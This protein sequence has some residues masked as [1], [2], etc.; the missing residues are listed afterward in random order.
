MASLIDVNSEWEFLD[1]VGGKAFNLYLMDQSGARVPRWFAISCHQ[2]NYYYAEL[3][4][5]ILEEIKKVSLSDLNSLRA[6]AQKIEDMFLEIELDES[7]FNEIEKRLNPE[8]SYSVRSSAKGEDGDQNSFAGQLATFLNCKGIEEVRMAIKK[9]WAS[10]FSERNIQYRILNEIHSAPEVGVIIQ[11]LIEVKSSGVM[12]TAHPLLTDDYLDQ[13]VI[14]AGYGLG[15]GIVS[16]TV[17]VDTYVYSKRKRAVIEHQHGEKTKMVV[18]NKT[19]TGTYISDVDPAK[20]TASVL[21]RSQIF[22]LVKLGLQLEELFKTQQDIEWCIDEQGTLYLTQTRPITTLLKGTDKL[23]FLFDNSNIVESFPGVNTPWTL[24]QVKDIYRI[25]FKRTCLRLGFGRNKINENSF[26]FASLL[27]LYRGRVYLNLTH[28]SA[29]MRLVPFTDR[30]VKAWEESLG[31]KTVAGDSRPEY[32]RDLFRAIIVFS[33]IIFYLIFLGPI[34]RRLDR[35]QRETFDQFWRDEPQFKALTPAEAINELESFKAK[36]FEN[37]EFTLINDIFAFSFTSFTKELIKKYSDLDPDQTFNSLLLGQ[38]SMDSVKPLNS[39]RQLVKLRFDS[40]ELDGVLRQ[41]IKQEN[42]PLKMI[43]KAQGGQTF[44][45]YFFD[46]IDSYGDRGVNELKLETMTF[47][48][49]P[50]D[51]LRLIL[52]YDRP[53]DSGGEESSM[54]S[55][56]L[57]GYLKNQLFQVCLKLAMRSIFFRE[58]FRLNRTRAYGVMRRMTNNLG[59][60]LEALDTLDNA[61]DIYF[62]DKEDLYQFYSGLSFDFDLKSIV[63]HKKQLYYQYKQVE[64]QHSYTFRQ[65]KFSE[66][67]SNK[68]ACHELKGTGCAAGKVVGEALVI[69]EIESMGIDA[70]AS[71][72]KILVAKMTDPG[73]VFLMA[74]SKGLLVEKGSLLSHTAIIGRELGV[75]TIVGV[76]GATNLIKTGDKIELDAYT[77]LVRILS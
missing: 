20:K 33:K 67:T 37:S 21:N 18:A 46:H 68:D 56:K 60:K 35:V 26:L 15:E 32:L 38:Q 77:G 24:G 22:E 42:L 28:W 76:A 52:S 7:F 31:V 50:R 3:K 64:V 72:D 71:R 47:R 36:I 55:V 41:T 34:L 2:F 17:E 12:F 5:A 9:V 43:A 14:N 23:D 53:L 30:Y 63:L 16:D 66:M 29:M 65:G 39:I 49:R 57:K 58:N 4:S 25:A 70:S 6:C 73:W 59:R 75:P 11:E 74:N 40:E 1:Q 13:I 44:L 27:A 45:N 61:R 62:L 48:E 8:L 54:P 19:K 10:V 69:T 51:L